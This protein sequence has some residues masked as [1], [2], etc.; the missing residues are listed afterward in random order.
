[1]HRRTLL[2]V[3]LR[4]LASA[5]AAGLLAACGRGRSTPPAA[6]PTLDA[7]GAVAPDAK[8]VLS[9][10]SGSFEQLTGKARP[11]AFGLVGSDNKPLTG[12]DV[13]VWAVPAAGGDPAGPYPAAFH[14]IPGQPLGL[15]LAEVDIARP[16]PTSFVAVTSDGRA[17]ADA[18]QV[19][20]PETSKLAAPG[21]AAIAVPTPTV[22]DPMGMT[23]LCTASPACGMHEISLDQ[24]L[25]DRRPVML[26]F[27]TPAYCMTAVC[28]PSVQVLDQVRTSRD[29]AEVAFVHV[30]I[31][32]DA[33]QTFSAP[34]KQWN[35]PSEPWLFAIA[36]DGRIADRADGPLL[37]LPDRVAAMTAR[38]R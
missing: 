5:G 38:I 20:T 14:E 32:A 25:R 28:G 35:L 12:A 4:T 2:H 7:V 16:G 29:W 30:E 10:V 18:V 9:V 23:R 37:T 3:L 36:R 31:Y 15:Y 19:A 6:A 27:A 24:A 26:T 13:K 22:A 17:G 33:G 11:F 8:E 1:M 34:V 21:R